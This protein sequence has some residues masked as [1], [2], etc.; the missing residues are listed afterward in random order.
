MVSGAR[1]RI[2]KP[3]L[4]TSAMSEIALRAPRRTPTDERTTLAQFAD[5]S[6]ASRERAA[7]ATDAPVPTLLEAALP[8][9]ELS[10]IAQ[11]DKR[12]SDPAYGAH[13]WWARRPPAVLRGILLAAGLGVDKK[14]EYW[15]LFAST[16]HTLKGLRV[17][18]PF[19]GGGSTLVEAARLGA[20]PSGT[21]VDPLAVTIVQHELDHP[22]SDVV[23][24]ASDHLMAEVE[25]DVAEIY[26]TAPG[27]W[28][29]LHYFF[30]HVVT[31][32]GC[33]R[34]AP[35]YRNLIIARDSGKVGGVVRDERI[36]AFCP[37]CFDI[38]RLK[39]G[40][41]RRLHCCG[42][43]QLDAGTFVAH[44]F[45]CPTCGHRSSH[46]ELST[47][48][49][50][51][52][53]IAVEETNPKA[54]RR[55]RKPGTRDA[56][57]LA[58]ASEL[59]ARERDQ[60]PL[61]TRDLERVR[62]DSRPLIF[63]IANPVQM[64]SDRQLLMF[65]RA[66]RWVSQYA[67]PPSVARALRLAVSN[68][69]T[70]NNKLCGYA[71]DYGR[72][73]PLFSVRS[74]PLPAL[75][76]ELNPLHKTAGRGTLR[77]AIERV[78]SSSDDEVRR[79]TWSQKRR[80]VEAIRSRYVLGH[81]EARVECKSATEALP[82]ADQVD[83]CVFDPPYYDYIA[84]SELSEFYRAWLV[85]YLGGAPLLPAGDDPVQCFGERLGRAMSRTLDRL[86][87]RRPLAF[88]YHSASADAWKAIGVALDTADLAVTA[89][90]PIL[91]DSHMGHHTHEGNCEWDVVVVCRRRAECSTVRPVWS[92]SSWRM[93]VRPLTI[94]KIDAVSIRLA[95]SMAECRA[96]SP[97]REHL[98]VA[99][100]AR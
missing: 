27:G 76:V 90:W 98:R 1:E 95:I 70:T 60:L 57:A 91:N 62:S 52:K 15:D 51:R 32:P 96:G 64:F 35:L 37:V 56:R 11:A 9:R 85:Q 87:P 42:V 7:V 13:R 18:D 3:L 81:A 14:L 31:C 21:D 40:D 55:I 79:Y 94:S 20:I 89:L 58:V 84:Y 67:G 65:G 92:V 99:G 61:P 77:R 22:P 50:P 53:L 49:A 5:P 97:R 80:K 33:R 73:A 41:Q 48:T 34:P 44:R 82:V 93:G 24:R 17:H 83:L 68:A 100:E 36:V 54:R 86:A 47:G 45:A 8:F 43:H 12:A 66:F 59:L 28:E 23:R 78:I 75:A 19:V 6:T 88:T 74:Y 39:R 29:P 38:H 26:P 2:V 63:G 16:E 10:L 25:R 46:R 4:P 72:L 71:T 30:L 69:L